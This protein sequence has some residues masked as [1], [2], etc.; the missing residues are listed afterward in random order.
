LEVAQT[1]D[2]E[3]DTLCYPK[4]ALFAFCLGLLASNAV[5]LLKGALRAVHGAQTVQEKVSGY[6]LALE[7][8]Q[9]YDGMMVAIPPEHWTVFRTCSDAEMAAVLRTLAEQASLRRYRKHPRGPKKKRPKRG[10][11]QNGAHVAT[12]K[13]LAARRCHEGTT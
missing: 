13:L 4:A 2:C 11:Y 3:I 7:I 8:R 9:T 1:L 12:A 5:A 10:A 6:Y